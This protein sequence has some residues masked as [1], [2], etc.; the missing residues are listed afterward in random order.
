MQQQQAPAKKKKKIKVPRVVNGIETMVEIEVDDEAGPEWG[1]NDKH[2]L[3]NRRLPRVDGPL[4]V[5]GA[6]QYTYDKHPP[7]MLHGRVLRS[8]HAHARVV[9]IDVS[10]ARKMPG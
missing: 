9:K 3:L 10:A 1:P 2:A 6:A 8:P 5:S 7:G 4:K